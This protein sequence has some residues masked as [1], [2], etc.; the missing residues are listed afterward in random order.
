M[1]SRAARGGFERVGLGSLPST[2]VLELTYACNHACLFCSCP[3]YGEGFEVLPELAVEDWRSIIAALVARGVSEFAF[4]GGEPLLK[5]GWREVV[6]F[7]RRLEVNRLE[8]VAP[9][10]STPKLHLTSNGRAMEDEDLCFLAEE[11]VHLMLSLPGVETYAEHTGGGDPERVLALFSAAQR[12]GLSTT[13][14]V[15]VTRRNLHE[16]YSTIGQAFLAG[17]G[18]LLLNR[19]LP[20]GRGT[21]HM[22]DLALD[23]DGLRTMLDEAEAALQDAGRTGHVGTELPVCAFDAGRLERLGVGTQCGA[24]STFFVVDPS[25]FVRV[26]NHS[27]VRLLPWTDLD[28]VWG[29]PRWRRF[30]LHDHQR[31]GCDDCALGHRCDAGCPEATEIAAS[32]RRNEATVPN[33]VT[34]QAGECHLQ[35]ANRL[36]LDGAPLVGQVRT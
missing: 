23:A 19:F 17:A 2:A 27:P 29:E 24:A 6:R 31:A 25:G 14:G 12:L 33:A 8:A 26:C 35:V 18:T 9:A 32:A 13:V 36:S 16:V 10:R 34:R 11:G 15:T 30:A 22:R 3:W 4:T 28:R 5:V 20:G 1:T 21:A 7:A